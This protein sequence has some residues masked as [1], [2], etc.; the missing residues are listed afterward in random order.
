[1]DLNGSI[2][3]DVLYWPRQIFH[4][5]ISK[6]ILFFMSHIIAPEVTIDSTPLLVELCSDSFDLETVNPSFN[7]L[8]NAAESIKEACSVSSKAINNAKANILLS[9]MADPKCR[10]W[11]KKEFQK[12]VDCDNTLLTSIARKAG[13]KFYTNDKKVIE[14]L[15]NCG[16]ETATEVIAQRAGVTEKLVERVKTKIQKKREDEILEEQI[17]IEVALAT[18]K[19]DSPKAEMES[20]EVNLSES[21]V[22]EEENTVEPIAEESAKGKPEVEMA[23]ALPTIQQVKVITGKVK[24][25]IEADYQKEIA[26]LKSQLSEKDAEIARLKAMLEE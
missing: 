18:E 7:E 4:I 15:E 8:E 13:F 3:I 25:K 19:D 10:R 20:V 16:E 22:T 23:R 12:R 11:L 9:Y 14:E 2:K 17:A 21:T 1:M 24:K 6:D 5:P 26:T